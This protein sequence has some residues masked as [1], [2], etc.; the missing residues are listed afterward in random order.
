MKLEGTQLAAEIYAADSEMATDLSC[1]RVL[2]LKVILAPILQ[3]VVKEYHDY[4]PEE[5]AEQFIDSAEI[6]L[7]REVSPGFSNR[8]ETIENESTESSVPGEGRLY[9]DI[10]VK[11]LLPREYRTSTQIVLHINV[12]A[13]KE[14]RP[15]YPIEKRGIYYISRMLSSQIEKVTEGISYAG[16]QKVYSIWICLGKDIPRR[17]QQTIT[18][19]YLA[20]EDLVGQVY[21]DES[22][23]DLLEMII[24]RLGDK[25]TEDKLL[26]MLTTL[27]WENLP[28]RERIRKLEE[29]YGIPMKRE[30]VEEVGKMCTYSAA[31]KERAMEEG[32]SEGLERGRSEGLELGRSEGLA[33]GRAEGRAEAICILLES[34]GEIPDEVRTKIFAEQ[35]SDTL[36]EWLRKAK[37]ADSVQEFCEMI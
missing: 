5:I 4:T 9:Y 32:R 10:K 14:Y 31:I 25:K 26:G 29:E 35:N 24:I 17:E 33:L 2:A 11:A 1:K 8:K 16:I 3:R 19:F 36:E 6:E 20:K 12:E 30:V 15:G 23:F 18:R 34:M 13:Q 27:L 22:K 37:K 7:F 28:V 21:I